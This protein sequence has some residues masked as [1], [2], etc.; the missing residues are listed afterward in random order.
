MK[1]CTQSEATYVDETFFNRLGYTLDQLMELAGLAVATVVHMEFPPST[2]PRVLVISGPGNNGGDGLVCARHLQYFGYTPAVWYP[3]PGN[4]PTLQNLVKQLGNHHIPV[5]AEQPGPLTSF[6]LIVDAI[7]GYSFNPPVRGIFAQIIQEVN[8]SSLPILSVDVPSG[9]NIDTGEHQTGIRAPTAV[10]SLSCPK[11][12]MEGYTGIHYLGGRFVPKV[13]SDEMG[14]DLPQ[15]PG[16]SQV[17][18]LQ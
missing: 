8:S 1:Y 4:A 16:H 11:K 5:M 12:C 7:F 18:K 15:Y 13:L 17:V 2:Y 9:W 14:L 10:I 6:D 3:K